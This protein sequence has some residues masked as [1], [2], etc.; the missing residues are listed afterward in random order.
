MKQTK[1]KSFPSNFCKRL[2]NITIHQE[3]PQITTL[4]ISTISP[5]LFLQNRERNL[6]KNS[7]YP[8]DLKKHNK[9]TSKIF[10]KEYIKSFNYNTLKNIQQKLYLN[11]NPQSETLFFVTLTLNTTKNTIKINPTN[12]NIHLKDFFILNTIKKIEQTQAQTLASPRAISREQK[13]SVYDYYYDF[14]RYIN[15]NWKPEAFKHF[16]I[17]ELQKREIWHIHLVTTHFFPPQA[18]HKCNLTN[19]NKTC[20]DCTYILNQ[21][22]PYGFTNIRK[23][24]AEKVKNQTQLF[25]YLIKYITKNLT[26]RITNPEKAQR[27]GFTKRV[28]LH[29]FFRSYKSKNQTI[30]IIKPTPHTSNSFLIKKDLLEN[31]LENQTF[32]KD[33]K[34][35]LKKPL[36]ETLVIDLFTFI[37]NCIYYSD[38][39]H[40]KERLEFENCQTCSCPFIDKRLKKGTYIKIKDCKD[41]CTCK[42]EG[43]EHYKKFP[44][45]IFHFSNQTF[46]KYIKPTFKHIN[47]RPFF[48]IK[49]WKPTPLDIEEAHVYLKKN[50]EI[51]SPLHPYTYRTKDKELDFKAWLSYLLTEKKELYNLTYHK[52]I[53]HCLKYDSLPY[54]YYITH[55]RNVYSLFDTAMDLEGIGGFSEDYNYIQ[56]QIN[57]FY[58]QSE[59]FT[60]PLYPSL[61]LPYRR[62][63]DPKTKEVEWLFK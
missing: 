26:L 17:F 1:N 40:Y 62:I 3:K 19:S 60:I 18:L 50:A 54:S 24:Q 29:K 59:T 12:K 37:E 2:L 13:K 23:V 43:Q 45:L 48:S 20:K 36:K 61:G 33:G 38:K 15:R 21:A 46:T 22:W 8:S 25:F 47:L 35:Y 14:I 51:K 52:K 55:T 4:K 7:I 32:T 42:K 39:N 28:R 63:V 31:I 30:K 44:L 9:E 56:S 49:K 11:F 53:T 57:I 5:N 16:A 34:K 6:F 41:T 58:P 27:L 10:L